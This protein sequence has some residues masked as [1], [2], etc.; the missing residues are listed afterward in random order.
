[1]KMKSKICVLVTIL[2]FYT[3]TTL[4]NMFVLKICRDSNNEDKTSNGTVVASIWEM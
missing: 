4:R 3:P 1:M 2:P